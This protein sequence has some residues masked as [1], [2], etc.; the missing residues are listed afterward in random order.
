MK[1]PDQEELVTFAL[2][3]PTDATLAAHVSDCDACTREVERL[4]D[5]VAATTRLGGEQIVLERPPDHVWSAILDS[6]LA[7]PAPTPS[8]VPPRRR[9]VVGAAL[10]GLAVGVA[11]TLAVVLVVDRD[12]PAPTP[13]A[14]RTI[15]SGQVSPLAASSSTSGSVTVVQHDGQRS[16]RIALKSAP[17]TSTEFVEA[18]LLDPSNNDMIALG[19]MAG[20]TE[21]F[22]LPD[23]VDLS[24]YSSVDISLEP[25][26]GDP[27]HSATSLARGPITQR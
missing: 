2:G 21:T 26:D 14:T 17:S 22:P 13:A 15:A 12:D 16:M 23:G 19:L 18:W 8:V 3:E 25:F 5:V 4:H 10:A 1:H 20:D 24:A 7:E 11:A 27:Q 6:T 9:R